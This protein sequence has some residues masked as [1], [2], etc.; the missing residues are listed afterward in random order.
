MRSTHWRREDFYG[1]AETLRSEMRQSLES[2]RDSLGRVEVD[3]DGW[4]MPPE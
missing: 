2:I 4:P 1:F 3:V